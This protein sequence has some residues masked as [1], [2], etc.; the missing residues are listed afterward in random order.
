MARTDVAAATNA[1]LVPVV[2]YGTDPRG[3][4]MF[5][6]LSGV[7]QRG[8]SG[9][10]GTRVLE[11]GAQWNGYAAPPQQFTGVAPL[12]NARPVVGRSSDLADERA[13]GPLNDLALSI[14]ADRLR[15]G[16]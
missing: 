3:W 5:H 7:L 12:G 9:R 13:A 11:R 10:E 1:R 16:R 2:E 4:A 8:I 6:A 14:F 15:R